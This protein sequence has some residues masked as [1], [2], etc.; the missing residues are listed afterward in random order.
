MFQLTTLLQND[1]VII[2][3]SGANQ[4]LSVVWLKHPDSNEFKSILRELPKLM[5]G[6][7]IRFLISDSRKILYLD[8]SSQNFLAQQF[9]PLLAREDT[10]TIAYVVSPASYDTMDI[11]RIS[12]IMKETPGLRD[13]LETSIFLSQEDAQEWITEQSRQHRRLAQASGTSI[14]G[15]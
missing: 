1:I 9:Y 11:Y 13:R 2:E 3:V 15:R 8:I 5:D 12:D 10:F 4:Y 6:K 7:Q 14:A